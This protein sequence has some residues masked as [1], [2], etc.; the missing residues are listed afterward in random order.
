MPREWVASE[1][2]EEATTLNSSK[3]VMHSTSTIFLERYDK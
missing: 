2:E 3:Q 1:E